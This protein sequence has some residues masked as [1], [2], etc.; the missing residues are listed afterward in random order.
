MIY[1]EMCRFVERVV[2]SQMRSCTVAAT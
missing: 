1:I 2:F